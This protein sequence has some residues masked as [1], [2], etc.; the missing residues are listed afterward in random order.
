[1]R[2]LLNN[3]TVDPDL[4]TIANARRVTINGKYLTAPLNGVHRVAGILTRSLLSNSADQLGTSIETR[5]LAPPQAA[6]APQFV[7]FS[8]QSVRGLLTSGQYWENVTLPLHSWNDVLISFCNLAP[9]IHPNSVVMIHDAQTFLKPDDYSDRQAKAYRK[10]LPIVGKS[11]RLVLTISNFAKQSLIKYGIAPAERIRIVPNGGDHILWQQADDKVLKT[12][13]LTGSRYYFAVGSTKRYKNIARLFE[14]FRQPE[15]ANRRLVLAGGADAEAYKRAGHTAPPNV[16]FTGMVSD[17]QLRSL[18]ENAHAFLFPSQ[19]EGFGL[20][21][22]EAM[23]CRCPV[24][25]AN[26]GAM[27]EICATGARFA[28]PEDTAQWVSAILALDS[29]ENRSELINAGAARSQALTWDQSR[30][31][32]IRALM[33]LV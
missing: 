18:Y 33:E 23:F 5:V 30:N 4:A 24:V 6:D 10:L 32:L 26:A 14:V 2:I 25:A 8:A 3:S 9:V 20:P 12:N 7:E 1:M 28:H 29:V 22:I 15:F 16:E 31:Y 13:K 27:P 11:A 19:T 21:P 17:P